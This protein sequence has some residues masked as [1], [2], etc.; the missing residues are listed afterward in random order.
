[1]S[2]PDRESRDL[3]GAAHLAREEDPGYDDRPH[4]SEY[5]DEPPTERECWA[6]GLIVLRADRECPRCGE[7]C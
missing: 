2:R 3:A 1:M 5:M 6:C 4:P 7:R